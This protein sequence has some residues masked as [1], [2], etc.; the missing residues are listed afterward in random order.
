MNVRLPWHFTIFMRIYLFGVALLFAF[1]LGIFAMLLSFVEPAN[2]AEMQRIGSWVAYDIAAETDPARRRKTLDSLRDKAQVALTLYDGRGARIDANTTMHPQSLS[3]AMIERVRS[4]QVFSIEHDERSSLVVHAADHV[5]LLEMI[6]PKSFVLG[7]WTLLSLLVGLS[8]VA[9]PIARSLTVPIRQLQTT[10]T[11]FGGGDVAVRASARGADEISQLAQ[12][13]NVM[14]NRIARL[15]QTER[16]LIAGV[17]HELRTPLQRI[18]IALELATDDG[19]ESSPQQRYI[20]SISTDLADL[21]HIVSD[22]LTISA[23]EISRADASS[24][25]LL[26]RREPVNPARLIRDCAARFEAAHTQ[27]RL[28]LRI[29]QRLPDVYAEPRLIHRAINNLL[30]NAHRHAPPETAIELSVDCREAQIVIAVCDQ[31]AGIAP[32]HLP[33]LFSPFYRADEARARAHGGA[34]LGLTIVKAIVEA[35]GG[36]VLVNS[37][38]GQGASFYIHLPEMPKFRRTTRNPHLPSTRPCRR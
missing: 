35:H 23:L 38:P 8:L 26:K 22:I 12:A 18:R 33:H 13:F 14:A 3:A 17:A 27:R 4:E 29:D 36:T 21:D 2:D 5:V 7:G 19:G 32:E 11:S 10:M 24:H 15:L 20:E 16:L 31:G 6:E 30:E 9:W 34:G 37:A 25:E 28:L 1:M